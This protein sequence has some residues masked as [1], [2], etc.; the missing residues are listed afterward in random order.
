MKKRCS[1][2]PRCVVLPAAAAWTCLL[3]GCASDRLNTVQVTHG[4]AAGVRRTVGQSFE[5]AYYRR[6]A[7]GKLQIALYT[8]SPVQ[9]DP[10][11]DITQIIL[12]TMSWQPHPGKTL[13]ERTMTDA[14][15]KYALING[16]HGTCYEGAGFV[17]VRRNER[18]GE[19]CGEIESA[20]LTLRRKSGN[21]V[22][23]FSGQARL[24]GHFT[25]QPSAADVARLTR[26]LNV[27]LGP[28]PGP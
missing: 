10:T 12:I 11:Q 17:S 8:R 3:V 21:P 23:I 14:I 7:G 4:D 9:S 5:Q 15:V 6:D 25:A 26:E 28:P 13:A 27:S 19:L 22:D 2:L 20:H 18:T 1:R 16:P 24:I